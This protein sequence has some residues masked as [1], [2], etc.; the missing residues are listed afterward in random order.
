MSEVPAGEAARQAALD[1]LALDTFTETAFDDITRM[2][3]D[4]FEVPIAAISIIDQDRQWFK[5][6]VGLG[7]SETSRDVAFCDHTIRQH[8]RVMVVED[9][10]KD[11]RFAAN[12]LVLEEPR[13]R[14]YAGAPL[15]LSSGL[16]IG[17]VCIVDTVPRTID[18][19][20]LDL[21]KFLA[22]QVTRTLESRQ[23]AAEKSRAAAESGR[24]LGRDAG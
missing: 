4:V 19:D 1:H 6:Q 22:Q 2:A 20:K 18:A 7:V 12:P 14:F 9:A 11:P 15:T 3:A 13:I 16:V 21:L 24:A 23:R 8:D 5:S 17:A 10:T